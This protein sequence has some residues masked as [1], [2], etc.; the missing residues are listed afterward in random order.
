MGLEE[1]A[2]LQPM[3]SIRSSDSDETLNCTKLEKRLGCILCFN[4]H[5]KKEK[6]GGGGPWLASLELNGNVTAQRE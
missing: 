6:R 3:K 5:K 4:G 2:S 1:R